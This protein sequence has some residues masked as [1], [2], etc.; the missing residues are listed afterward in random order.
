MP[1]AQ[2]NARL[3]EA[4]KRE[5]DATL[6]RYG[7]SATEAIRSLWS[8]LG[9]TQELP[10]FLSPATSGAERPGRSPHVTRDEAHAAQGA[11][12]AVR[13]AQDKGLATSGIG[14]VSYEQLRALALDELLKEGR[15]HA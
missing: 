12:L 8:Y 2:L 5:G 4:V 3:D 13:L 1:T 10:D 6:A 9:S 14:Q 7:I 15:I 11:G